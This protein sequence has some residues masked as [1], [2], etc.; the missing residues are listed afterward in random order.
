MITIKC[1]LQNSPKSQKQSMMI[2][3]LSCKS[4][5][6]GQKSQTGLGVDDVLSDTHLEMISWTSSFSSKKWSKETRLS[7][8]VF[9]IYFLRKKTSLLILLM[10]RFSFNRTFKKWGRDTWLCNIILQNWSKETS[11]NV[12]L[13]IFGIFETKIQ[14]IRTTRGVTRIHT[15]LNGS[16]AQLYRVFSASFVYTSGTAQLATPSPQY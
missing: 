6:I 5:K 8:K 10:H 14:I 4:W 16:L 2:L 1:A 12:F 9:F 7:K 11:Y 15:T 3:L 13:V